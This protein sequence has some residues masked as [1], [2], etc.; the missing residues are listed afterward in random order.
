MFPY[1]QKLSKAAVCISGYTFEFSEYEE[2][3]TWCTSR[4]QH[5]Y[6]QMKL[7]NKMYA[8]NPCVEK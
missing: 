6:K 3:I 1:I 8:S 2:D 5:F 4:N 7:M